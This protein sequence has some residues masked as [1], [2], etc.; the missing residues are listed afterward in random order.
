MIISPTLLLILIS[1]ILTIGMVL[2][3]IS[4]KKSVE[5]KFNLSIYGWIVSLITYSILCY[6]TIAPLLGV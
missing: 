2:I 3:L 1:V 5:S 4:L 6:K